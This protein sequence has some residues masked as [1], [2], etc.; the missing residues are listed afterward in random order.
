MSYYGKKY[1]PQYFLEELSHKEVLHT[2]FLFVTNIE[3]FS[4][5]CRLLD[6]KESNNDNDGNN[7]KQ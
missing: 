3:F 6:E 7:E 2:F 5:D 1:Y 4:S